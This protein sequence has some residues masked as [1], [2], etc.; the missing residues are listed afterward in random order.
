MAKML[1]VFTNI[2][3]KV[4]NTV[5]Q[6]IKGV[7]IMKTLSTPANPQ[8]SRQTAVRSVFN[9]LVQ[10]FKTIAVSMIRPFWNPYTTDNKTGWGNLLSVNQSAMQSAGFD[11]TKLVT[12]LGT[13]EGVGDLAGTYNTATG[14]IVVTWGG[15]VFTNGDI[16][17]SIS[18]I[19]I[20]EP[21]KAVIGK[22]VASDARGDETATFNVPDGLTATD[23]CVFVTMSSKII[24]TVDPY[25]VSDSQSCECIAPV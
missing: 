9:D 10:L 19:A 22:A 16:A 7:Q 15:T 18:F 3:G 23:V 6:V 21:T 12:S 5:F 20:H 4:G 14:A 17:D 13:L 1:G 25:T 2:R 11:I 8:S 24:P